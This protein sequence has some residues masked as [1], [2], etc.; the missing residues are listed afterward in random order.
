MITN[1]IKIAW[2]NLLKNNGYSSINILGLAIGLACCLLVVL[3]IQDELSFDHYHTKKDRIYRVVHDWKEKNGMETQQIWGNAPVGAALKADFPEVQTVVQFSGQIS[4]L[5]KQGEKAF[6]EERV[7]CMDSTAFDMFSWTCIAGNPHTALA[8]PYSIVLTETMAKKYFADSNP[9]GQTLEGGV[10]GGRAA[11]GIYTVTAVIKDLPSNSHFT[12][13]ALLSMSS[14]RQ[15][16]AEVFEQWGY[17]DFYTYLLL[18][19]GY[20]IHKLEKQVPDF[21]ARHQAS[22]D[23]KYSIHFEPMLGAYLNS[24]ADRQP[25]PVGNMQNIYIFAIIG[26]FILCIACVNFMNLATS[27]SLERAKEVG[28]R[29]VVGASRK[30]LIVQFMSESLLLVVFAA[31]LAL[32]LV[33]CSLPFMEMFAGKRFALSS[34]FQ[35]QTFSLFI[36]IVLVTS[37]VA[38]SYPA[39]VLA[40]FKPVKVFKGSSGL[41]MG[42]T[43]LRKGLVVFQFG[44]S[45]ALI[46]G[47]LIVFSQLRHLQQT[48]LGFQKTQMLVIDFNY[49]NQVLQNLDAIKQTFAQQKDV[50][51]VSASRSIPGS[52][53]PNAGTQIELPDGEMKPLNQA[54]FEVDVDFIANF[55]IQMAAGRP[56]S[57]D[58]PA[59][60][61][62]SLVINEAAAKLWGY[63]DPEKI[64]GKRFAQWGREGQVI[65]VVK[66]FNYLSLHQKIEP[67]TLRLE[68]L[69]SKFITL[70]IQQ[71]SNPETIAKLADI[72]STVAPHRPFLYSFLDNSF[73]RQY[74][75]DYRFRRLFS[76]FSGLALF[77]A[78]LGLLGLATYTAQQRTKEI[79]VRKVLGASTFSIV[80]LLSIDFLRLVIIALFIAVPLAWWAMNQWLSDFAYHITIPWWIFAI[81]GASS[82]FIALFTISGQAI[83]ASMANP[84]DSLRDE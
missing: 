5:L 61:I 56:Y 52:Y 30:N 7:F 43:W 83:R 26:A 12:F 31:L 77:I 46:A 42:G 67:L 64:I 70:K 32:A 19:D 69:S 58:F 62:N 37:L 48:D 35:M 33:I 41:A 14:F 53:F 49:D 79:G 24:K 6:Q 50:L 25:G 66:D 1:Y 13:D 40:N 63:P 10:T 11:P 23:G 44:L 59:D 45:I 84:V 60:T 22:Q 55:G 21:I 81:A 15:S 68:P 28:V 9:I 27:R 20:D 73:N 17:V 16:W 2:R 72:W 38:A 39:F 36:G 3:Y 71:A 18:P 29:K 47:T 54:I 80:K 78:C 74:E 65:G 4:I 57:R 34:L 8:A 76:A 51:S 75:A 82:L